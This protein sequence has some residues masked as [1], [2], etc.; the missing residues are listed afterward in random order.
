LSGL[1]SRVEVPDLASRVDRLDALCRRT[2]DIL[3]IGGGITGAAVARD[4]ASRGL[5]VAIVERNDWGSGTSWRS[6]KLVHGGLRY[7]RQG[8]VHLVFESLAER[9]RLLRLAPHLV[10]PI[11]FLFAVL[12]GRWVSPAALSAGLTLYDLLA[13]GRGGSWHRRLSPGR[14]LAEEPLFSGAGLSGGALYSD[15]AADDARLTLENVL[16]ASALGAVAVSRVESVGLLR[17]ESGRT[18][19]SALRD[20]ESGRDFEVRARVTIDATGPW[21]DER[22]RRA[23]PGAAPRLRLSRGSHVTVPFERLPVRRAVAVPV[24]SG[25]LFFAIPSG[26]VTL[27]GTT[28]AEYAGPADGVAPT[29]EDVAYIFAR[30]AETFPGVRLAPSDAVAAFAGLR[31]LRV[32]PGRRAS[33]TSR[34]EAIEAEDGWLSVIGGKLTTHRRMAGRILDAARP[35]LMRGGGGAPASPPGAQATKDRPFPGTPGEGPAA[36]ATLVDAFVREAGRDG[37]APELARHLAGRYGS[38]AHGVLRILR[39]DLAA[40]APLVRGFPD[41]EA[42]VRFAARFE[43]ARAAADVLVRRTHLFWQ[44]PGQAEEAVPRVHAILA[45]EIGAGAAREERST[46]ELSHEIARS[47]AAL[48]F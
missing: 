41:C 39:A 6:S 35:M 44:A 22:R 3:V 17:D 31:P 36:L 10:R 33:E 23:V 24:E 11:E 30:A 12:P 8:R 43:D 18:V 34:E 5:S 42:E 37:I 38:R 4:A 1:T 16:D 20:V 25:R 32:E 21:S 7:L 28:E 48:T 27:L 29:R 15:A 14:A 2:F 13:L 9:A 19:G 47:R 26:P 40:A 46:A 45:R